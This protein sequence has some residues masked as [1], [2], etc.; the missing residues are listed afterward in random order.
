[1]GSRVRA[2]PSPHRILDSLQLLSALP[3][4]WLARKSEHGSALP[5]ERRTTV[6]SAKTAEQESRRVRRFTAVTNADGSRKIR[7]IRQNSV[8]N[9]ATC[10]MITIKNKGD[11]TDGGTARI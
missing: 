2:M 1:M 9:A 10:S 7:T 4:L 3:E 8:P 5:A 11:E 6:S